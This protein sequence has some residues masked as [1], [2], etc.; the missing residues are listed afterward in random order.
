[1]LRI[2]ATDHAGNEG[3]FE[4]SLIVDNTPPVFGP[5]DDINANA[6]TADGTTVNFTVTATDALATNVSVQCTP[7]SGSTFPLGTTN[8]MCTATDQAG[9]IASASFDV[10]VTDTTAPI[11]NAASLPSLAQAEATGAAG[12]S[13]AYTLPTASDNVDPNPGVNCVPASES[14]FAIG[15]TTVTCTATDSRNNSSVATFT[16]TVTDTTGPVFANVPSNFIQAATDANG[17]T[18]SYAEPTATD[19]V[20]GNVAVR[21][22]PFSGSLFPITTTTVTCTATDSHNNTST[23]T[24]T[25]TVAD[26]V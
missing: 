22:D 1:M 7:A 21:C 3:S 12:A 8:V 2:V 20:D 6:A 18:V 5:L 26:L 24:F 23:A 25:V 14:T 15:T 9:N 17:A 11:I 16:V 13:V 4:A 10:V 19:S